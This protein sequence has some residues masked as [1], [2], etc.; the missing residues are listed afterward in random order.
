MDLP[1]TESVFDFDFTSDLGKRYEG[2]FTVRCLLNMRQKHFLELEKTRL[3]GNYPNP[4]DELAGIAIILATLRGRIIDGPDWWKQSDGGFNIVD[5]DTLNVL[6]DKVTNA[7]VEWRTA[8]K[9]KAKKAQETPPAPAS[10]PSST[11]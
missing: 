6:F 2:R 3:L 1:P 5:F 7:E 10:S 4:T 8:L 11:Q 9:E